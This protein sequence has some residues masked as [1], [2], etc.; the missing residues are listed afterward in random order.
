[1]FSDSQKTALAVG[2][3]LF[4]MLLAFARLLGGLV[5]LT[6]DIF[7]RPVVERGLEILALFGLILN[8]ITKVYFRLKVLN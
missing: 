7:V 8:P 6:D 3:S 1:M 5:E 2:R 4:P